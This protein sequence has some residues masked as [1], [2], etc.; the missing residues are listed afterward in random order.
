MT[1]TLEQISRS[2]LHKVAALTR[3]EEI[4]KYNGAQ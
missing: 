1:E 2:C 3:S 4:T